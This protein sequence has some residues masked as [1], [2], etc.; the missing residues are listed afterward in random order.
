MSLYGYFDKGSRRYNIKFHYNKTFSGD[1]DY[2]ASGSWTKSMRPDYSLSIWPD[3]IDA[4]T[5]EKEELI[6]HIH[7]DSKYKV[8][9][10]KDIFIDEETEEDVSFKR[11]D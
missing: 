8:E 2:P 3:G 9:N 1:Q 10:I 5:A 7:F 6:V 4:E 11:I